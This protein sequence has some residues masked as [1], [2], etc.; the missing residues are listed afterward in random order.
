MTFLL[1]NKQPIDIEE[2][3][4]VFEMNSPE[5][6]AYLD[7]QSGKIVQVGEFEDGGEQRIDQY[8]NL[9]ERYLPVQLLTTREH[10]NWMKEFSDMVI[11]DE[12]PILYE[13]VL[14]ALNGRGAFRRFQDVLAD[15]GDGSW[16]YA[17][18]EW[19]AD[20]AYEAAR[21]WLLSLPIDIKEQF[22]GD[23]DCA[24]CQLLE[25]GVDS[26]EEII[27][28][29]GLERAKESLRTMNFHPQKEIKEILKR[30]CAV[31]GDDI[32]VVW[33]MDRTFSG[34]H[35]FSAENGNAQYWKCD[36]CVTDKNNDT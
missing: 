15:Y 29:F 18:F 7:I 33:Y 16:R 10:Y 4:N 22:K 26:Q 19:K 28:A 32:D 11:K 1:P 31:C 36:F 14:S 25:Q 13:K 17:W 8:D 5:I 21:E 6:H 2:L 24:L 23:D 9:P 3:L 20:C 34:G 30:I 27:D 12:E 35:V